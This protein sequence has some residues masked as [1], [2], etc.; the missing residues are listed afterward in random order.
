MK[1]VLALDIGNAFGKVS[2]L[3][4]QDKDPISL[5]PVHMQSGMPT[6]AYVNAVGKIEVG[7]VKKN[8]RKAMVVS[9]KNR[10]N[11]T[12]QLE[13]NGVKY[14][15]APDKVYAAIA[16]K[17]V[18]HANEYL[19]AR[20]SEP[21]YDVVVTY[22]AVFVENETVRNRFK[23]AVESVVID[24]HRL[25]VLNMLSEPMA[26]AIDELYF[27][28]R[29]K[30]GNT[31]QKDH[32]ILVYDLGHG[33]L[34]IAVL[35]ATA[36]EQEPFNHVFQDGDS[37]IGGRI[38]DRLLYKELCRQLE[39]SDNSVTINA[40]LE[41]QMERIA[42]EIKHELSNEDVEIAERD[43]V[44]GDE[45]VTVSITREQFE[46][47]IR[48]VLHPSFEMVAEYIE[49]AAQQNIS[50]DKIVLTGGSSRIPYI[51]KTLESLTEGKIPV[52]SFRYINAVAFGAARFAYNIK[53]LSEDNDN[54]DGNSILKQFTEY[55]Y[56]MVVNDKE[57]LSKVQFVI[58]SGDQ[59]PAKSEEFMVVSPTTRHKVRVRR[60]VERGVKG[61]CAQNEECK[62]Y[63]DIPF[64]VPT[65]QACGYTIE[66]GEDRFVKVTCRYP[67]GKLVTKNSNDV[68]K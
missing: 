6:A 62:F 16:S 11:E 1:N 52:I 51:K 49:R 22:P 23:A 63:C 37:E 65:G 15:V 9:V 10:F 30:K 32:S 33:T 48:D 27:S 5:L 57:T 31:T 38:F 66:M 35:T 59:L 41:D 58:K 26:A 12:I 13:E 54:N 64:D 61:D 4:L 60:S 50:V 56:G 21:I 17:L 44:F 19:A 55:A 47:L 39:E 2:L 20:G 28:Q 34:D 68:W 24:G 45:D 18:T 42:V 46:N 36:D 25:R 3:E 53:E 8:R 7:T 29:L 67:D 43:L 14:E 40:N